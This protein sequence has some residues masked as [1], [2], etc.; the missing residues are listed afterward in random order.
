MAEFSLD[1]PEI[2]KS[3][4]QS[5]EDEKSKLPTDTI[6]IRA[7]ENALAIFN[8]DF[9]DVQ[10]R[11]KIIKPLEN[12]GL[13]TINRSSNKNNLLNA[14]FI[15]ITKGGDD[16]KDIGNNLMKLNRQV[17]ILNP[18]DVDFSDKGLLGKIFNPIK[19]Y[20]DKYEKAEGVI[21]DIIK[22]LDESSRVLQN[23][24]VTLLSE[25][26]A[27]RELSRNLIT[28]I[29]LAKQMDA[30]ISAQIEEARFQ[31]IEPEKIDFV[32]EE[33]LFPLRQRIMDMQQMIVVNQHGIVS[34]NV[35]RRNNKELIRGI[36]RAQ[37]VTVTALRT[38]IMVAAALYNQKVTMDKIKVLNNTTE[39]IIESTSEILRRQGTEIQKASSETMLSPEVLQDSFNEALAAIEDLSSYKTQAL[40]QM[41]ETINT[42]SKM[43]IDGEKIFKKI[44]TGDK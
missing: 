27:L 15:D 34:L 9:D 3:V 33:I 8:T 20:F 22:S 25:E 39:D 14:R 17:E 30:S 32:R 7:D 13:T 36:E 6:Q 38:G 40:S 23:D 11:E 19:R 5:L 1:I 35:I 4:S 28:D 42:F 26:E 21:D 16:A 43:A 2:E 29:E 37:N 41:Q 44:E 12:F 10:E 24:N 31:E 18:K